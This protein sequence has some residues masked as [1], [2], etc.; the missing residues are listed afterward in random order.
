MAFSYYSR[1]TAR[2]QAIYRASDRVATITLPRPSALLPL[3]NALR[4]ALSED[5][6]RG[7]ALAVQ[8]LSQA[9]LDQLHTPRLTLKVLAVRPSRRWGELHGLYTADENRPAEIRLWMRTARQARVVAFRTFLRTLLHELCHHL[10][11]HALALGDSFHTEGFFRRESSLFRQ[12][13]PDALPGRPRAHPRPRRGVNAA[14]G[15]KRRDGR[16]PLVLA[17]DPVTAVGD[18]QGRIRF[19]SD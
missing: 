15:K 8:S 7:V 6:R 14:H 13:V 19:D 5:D 11:Y 3:V 16:A 17:Q 1:L 18:R 12:L 9:L 10:D 2:Q 4:G